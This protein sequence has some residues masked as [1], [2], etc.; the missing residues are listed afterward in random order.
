MNNDGSRKVGYSA[1]SISGQ[2]DCIRRALTLSGVQPAEISYVEA[3][4]TGTRVG[5]PIELAGL[6]DA[7]RAVSREPLRTGFCAVASV[8]S[9]IGHLGQAAGMAALIKTVLALAHRQLPPSINVTAPNPEF[10]WDTSPFY[11]NTSLRD[12]PAEPGRPR[13]AGVSSFGI[14]GTNAHA[15]VEEA[16]PPA[17]RPRRRRPVEVLTWSAASTAAETQ[18]RERLAGHFETLPEEDFADAAHTLRVGRTRRR[19]RAALVATGAADAARRLRDGRYLRTG[20]DVAREIVFAFPGQGAQ[21]HGMLRDLYEDEPLFRSGCDAAFEVL[22]P[23]LDRDLRAL[24]LSPE[25]DPELTETDVTQPLMYVLESTLA[26]CLMHW[27]VQP[28]VLVGHSLGEFVAG[29][30]AGVLGFEDG[31]R[32]VA[33]RAQ[34]IGR[35][36]R[37]RMLAVGAPVEKVEDQLTGRVVVAAVNSARE[38]VLSGDE[39]DLREVAQRLAAQG[40]HSRELATSHAF[41][42]PAMA[43]AA[44]EWEAV[45]RDL[46]LRPPEIPVL[47]A[48]TGALL[49]SGDATSPRFWA[50]Q[51]VQPVRFAAAAEELLDRGPA[52]VLEVGPGRTLLALLRAGRGDQ[53]SGSRFLPTTGGEPGTALQA[54]LAQL[55]ADGVPVSA[56]EEDG[57]RG[58]RRVVVPG[59][60]Y[61]RRRFWVEPTDLPVPSGGPAPDATSA[62]APAPLPSVAASVPEAVAGTGNRWRFGELRWTPSSATVTGPVPP[63]ARIGRALLLAASDDPAVRSVQA[64]LQRAGYR[65]RILVDSGRHG[66]DQW[67]AQLGLRSAEPGDG[68]ILLVHATLLDAPARVRAADL[69]RQLAA[70][71]EALFATLRAAAAVQRRLRVPVRLAVLGRG[72]VDVTGGES[73]NPASAAVLGLLRSAELEVPGL[74][75]QLVDVGDRPAESALSDALAGEDPLIAVRGA[76]RWSPWLAESVSTPVAPA[77][78]ERGIYLV[79]GGLGGIGL[80]LARALAESGARPNLVLVGRTEV[81]SRADRAAVEQQ[82]AA[83]EEAGATV[84]AFGCDVTDTAALARVADAVETRLGPVNGV[85]HAAGVPGGGLLERRSIAEL[86]AVL[87]PKAAGVLAIDEVFADRAP[88]DFLVLCSSLAGA[89]GMY[90]SAD[91]AAANAFLDAY[92]V[93]RS[94]ARRRT[95]SVQWPGWAEVGMLARSPEGRAVLN[96]SSLN[97]S[98]RPPTEPAPTGSST[99]TSSTAS[100][101]CPAR[102]CCS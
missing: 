97:G 50:Q 71:V 66:A 46:P 75:C 99:S 70:G 90:G 31:L 34:A 80:V 1:P 21:Q 24:W 96:G 4:G 30:V 3:H 85:V 89:T 7:Y 12:W 35:A 98:S 15:V 87:A 61:Q 86:R 78:R 14:G 62:R 2:S 41:H 95:I 43:A 73:V 6:V 100:R 11:L 26:H 29:T 25:P 20:D 18:L 67:I 51:L 17:Q 44:Q 101:C 82:L 68:R 38:V 88:L 53:L 9:N 65:T 16:P 54:A 76:V 8:K 52:H 83:L 55:W 48:A 102:A 39:D 59:Y 58:Y 91:Y 49:A 45:L 74:R 92:S 93:S 23:L 27:G 64:A 60:P 81:A 5:D 32:A 13:R 33:H 77:V 84:L 22:R 28:D 42:S 10:G 40:L 63:A 47:S 72:L 57:A 56:W 37:G 79:P 36:P 69:D 94:S 19:V